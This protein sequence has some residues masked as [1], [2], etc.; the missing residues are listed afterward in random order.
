MNPPIET[1]MMGLFKRG[2]LSRDLGFRNP[3]DRS[4][5]NG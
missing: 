5:E 4:V 1:L 2:S 3:V